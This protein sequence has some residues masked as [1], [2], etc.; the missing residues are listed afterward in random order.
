VSLFNWIK[1]TYAQ[2][3][4]ELNELKRQ[5]FIINH[6]ENQEVG[7]YVLD[8]HDRSKLCIL[9]ESVLIDLNEEIFALSEELAMLFASFNLRTQKDGVGTPIRE[10]SSLTRERIS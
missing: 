5:V 6:Q 10:P 3:I 4:D 2:K 9:I 1:D 7:S 8:H